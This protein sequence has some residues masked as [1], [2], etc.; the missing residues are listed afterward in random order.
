[1]ETAVGTLR[2][3]PLNPVHR[4]LGA[5]L[6]AFGGWE[7]PVEYSGLISEHMAVRSAA[8]L[9]DVSHMGELEVEGPGA[10]A[11]LQRVTSNDVAKLAEGQA[12]YTALPLPS[13]APADD[14]ILYRRGPERFLLVV[15]ASNT[16]KDLCWL[17]QQSP[18]GCTVENRSD[19]YSLIALQGP[20]SESVL[21]GLTALDLPAIRYYHFADGEV[22]GHAVTVART[23]YT[24]EDGF[25]IFVAPDAAADLWRKLLE[26][27]RDAG[28]VPA[29]LGARDTLRLEARMCLYGNDMDETTTLVE[30]GLGWIV[31]LD[32]AKGDFVGRGVLE[33]QKKEGAPRKLVGFEMV[34]RGIARHGYPVYVGDEPAG[35]V[36]SG[37]YA[38]FLQKNIGLCYLPT[39]RAAT[40]TPF[41]VDIRG[42]RVAAKVV[43]TPFYKRPR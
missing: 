41:H 10:A 2:K 29:G 15:N 25:E 18:T 28:L 9:F 19:D 8:G 26:A 24:G 13:G 11:F 17:R 31:S 23:G 35:A 22:A 1:M 43:P 16:E 6:V 5:K 40:G 38:P 42:R 36:T 7:M 21:Q 20:R 39:P 32:E 4:E 34:D 27:G 30:A 14:V 12:Q 37:S 3:T 33:A